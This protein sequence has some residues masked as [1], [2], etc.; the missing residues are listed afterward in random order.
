MLNTNI[1]QVIR[2]VKKGEATAQREL[3]ERF[4][5]KMLAVCRQY[6]T[7]IHNAED[8][9]VQGFIKVFKNIDQFSGTGSFEGWIRRI[10]VNESI[11]FIRSKKRLEDIDNH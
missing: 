8:V 1:E 6:V 11:S 9:L 7:D 3:Y 10:M 2:G 4:S 5:P